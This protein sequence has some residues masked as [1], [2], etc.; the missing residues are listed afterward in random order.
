MARDKRPDACPAC[1]GTA[2][3]TSGHAGGRQRGRCEGCGR[4]FTRPEPRGEP[5]ELKRHAIEL[6]CLGL[7]MNAVAK[8]IGV[9]ARSM[10]R[11]VRDHAQAHGPAPEPTASTAGVEVDEMGHLVKN[12]RGPLFRL[13]PEKQA[14]LCSAA[15]GS[16]RRLFGGT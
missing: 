7:S 5:A 2:L 16:H 10:L 1:R 8:H 9:S 4:Q 3:I 6:C 11:W 12:H 13:G 15:E 14:S